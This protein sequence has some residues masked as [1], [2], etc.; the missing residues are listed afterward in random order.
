MKTQGQRCHGAL[1]SPRQLLHFAA[2]WL[3]ITISTPQPARARPKP[4]EG[5]PAVNAGDIPELADLLKRAQW[6]TTPELSGIFQPGHIFEVTELGHR[7]LADT[8]VAATPRENTYT[9]TEIVSRLQAGVSLGFIAEAEGAWV[10]HVRF[11]TPRQISIPLLDLELTTSCKT[12]LAKLSDEVIGRSYVIQEVLRAEIAEQ[13]CGR[14]DTKG[15]VVGLGAADMEFARAC[16]QTSLEPVAVGYRTIP[17]AQLMGK[18]TPGAQGKA[19]Q[20]NN[21]PTL[22][23]PTQTH[24]GSASDATGSPGSEGL[25]AQSPPRGAPIEVRAE[26]STASLR[27]KERPSR[28]SSHQDPHPKVDLG[29]YVGSMAGARATFWPKGTERWGLGVRAG[30]SATFVPDNG[31][32]GFGELAI[33]GEFFGPGAWGGLCS[34][35]IATSAVDQGVTVDM[36]LL[37]KTKPHFRWE[38]GWGGGRTLG[39]DSNLFLQPRIAAAW[40]W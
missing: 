16:S 25:D 20:S 2:V 33:E 9:A 24:A 12:R 22:P 28:A 23:V 38:W 26:R 4:T 7:P 37:W 17:L 32:G 29:V 5:G 3:A 35:G 18:S 39:A 34:A 31:W 36:M 30:A 27:S 21:V 10:K 19:G 13:T 15:R 1:P 14:L 40:S 11:G 6:E 8:C